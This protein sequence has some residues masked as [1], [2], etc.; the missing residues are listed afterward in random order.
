MLDNPAAEPT[1]S[2]D[3][4]RPC[5]TRRTNPSRRPG[6][7][8]IEPPAG[9][10]S[11]KTVRKLFQ[12]QGPGRDRAAVDRATPIVQRDPGDP[13]ERRFDRALH[14]MRRIGVTR[15]IRPHRAGDAQKSGVLAGA[16]V[17]ERGGLASGPRQRLRGGRMDR[18]VRPAGERGR[19]EP[20]AREHALDQCDVRRLTRVR[21]R[22]E[23]QLVLAEAEAIRGTGFDERQRLQRLDRGTGKHRA[24]DVAQA[25]HCVAVGIDHGGCAAMLALEE[26]AADDF[27]EYRICHKLAPARK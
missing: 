2:G 13:L 23:R 24:R 9:A 14:R 22:C 11:R 7:V 17:V 12:R 18:R 5:R 27:D 25:E 20:G 6:P 21:S 19:I 1:G 15:R 3:E 4:M 8:R 10:E 26:R 16:I